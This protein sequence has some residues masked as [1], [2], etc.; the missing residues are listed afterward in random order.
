M[1]PKPASLFLFI[2]LFLLLLFSFG[3]DVRAGLFLEAESFDELGGWVV[4][5][6]SMHSMGSSY[7]MA[8]GYGT[9]VA[10]AKTTFSVPESGTYAVYARTRDWTAVWKRGTSAGRFQILINGSELPTVLGTNGERWDWQKAGTVALDAG[11][12]TIELKDLT[13]FNG[14]CDAIYLAKDPADVPESDNG[15]LADFRNKQTGVRL[16]DS[17]DQ[18]DL[19]VV[20]GG[21]SGIGAAM[22]AERTGCKVLLLQD[23]EVLGGCNSSEIRVGLGGHVNVAPYPNLGNIVREIQPMHGGGGTYSKEYYEDARKEI[24]FRRP[25]CNVK[26]L[27][28]EHVYALEMDK[29][30]PKR[31]A[32]V[33]SRNT[34]SGAETRFSAPLFV[35]AT[36]DAVLARMAGCEVMYGREA[37]DRF[38]EINAPVQADRQVMGQSVL[39]YARKLHEQPVAFPDIDWAIP[40]TDE[41]AYYIRGGDWEQEAGQY[42]DMAEEA[43]YIRDYSLLSIYSN[44]SFLVNHSKRKDEFNRY[45]IDW[46]SPIGGK[47]ESYRV[48]GDL[49]LNQ[50]DLED[51]VYHE[52]QTGA[53]TWDI[54]LHFPDPINVERFGEPFRS[55]AYHRGFGEWYPVPYR[56]L[57]A[58]D[59]DNLFLAG[60]HIS[61]SHVAFA[62]VRVMRTLGMLGEVV[63]IAATIC[64]DND[65]LPRD[66]YSKHLDT[67]KLMMERGVPKT[68]LYH[69]YGGGLYE[70][71]H[72]KELGFIRISPNPSGDLSEELIRRIKLLGMVHRQE[73]PL[74]EN[75]EL[76]KASNSF[77]INC[78]DQL[79]K[80]IAIKGETVTLVWSKSDEKALKTPNI[81]IDQDGTLFCFGRNSLGIW[82]KDVR[83]L[84]DCLTINAGG[85]LKGTGGSHTNLGPVVLNGGAISSDNDGDGSAIMGNFCLAGK[86]TATGDS[87]I[88]AKRISLRSDLSQ[89][90]GG[91]GVFDVPEAADTLTITSAIHAYGGTVTLTKRGKGKLLLKGEIGPSV[92]IVA[93]EGTVE[94]PDGTVKTK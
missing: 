74:L 85:T 4:D 47:R 6:H 49:V 78:A 52:D 5:P 20:G 13:G 10:N 26:L 94:M 86:V 72:F 17:P 7:V 69:A 58:R 43:E 56:C 18:Y 80:P 57:Y 71:Y 59:C 93:E 9:P 29:S 24:I 63:G 33:L 35:D 90:D 28:R 40:F 75:S 1:T 82:T 23:R 92:R 54:D 84:P 16:K 15:K 70:S 73:H 3:A 27:F 2:P 53:I 21:M 60:R 89:V 77:G 48:V 44:W 79:E 91:S 46:V 66:V 14:R 67:L 36:G 25:G 55:C 30:N 11:K 65:C 68:P 34:Y 62:A 12:A 76:L 88:D 83:T 41:T 38:N 37:R 39:W 19:I 32:A 51:H 8:H 64:R 45:S 42:R 31:I 61:V 50:N 81:T 22:A 87:R